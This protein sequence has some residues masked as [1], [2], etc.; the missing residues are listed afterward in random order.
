MW[1][2]AIFGCHPEKTTHA[3]YAFLVK[4]VVDI[5]CEVGADRLLGQ[6][7]LPRPLSDQRV[8][9]LEAVIAGKN[10]IAINTLI[11][12]SAPRSGVRR[13]RPD[14]GDEGKTGKLSPFFGQV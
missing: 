14:R 10:E 9:V 7:H 3:F 12:K 11:Q 6:R 8:D 4:N 5:G 1:Q 13:N 2:D